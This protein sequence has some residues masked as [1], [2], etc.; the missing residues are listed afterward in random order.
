MLTL[1]STHGK[2]EEDY[3]NLA[4][5]VREKGTIEDLF[6]LMISWDVWFRRNHKVYEHKDLNFEQVME[7]AYHYKPNTSLLKIIQES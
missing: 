4:N 5:L 3:A 2:K 7:H 1:H 6:F